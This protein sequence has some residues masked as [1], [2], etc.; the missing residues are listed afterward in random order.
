M[1]PIWLLLVGALS[2]YSAQDDTVKVAAVAP[3]IIDGRLDDLCW[4]RGAWQSIDQVWITYGQKLDPGDFSGRYK[5][6]WSPSSGLLYLLVETVDDV[7]VDGYV[8]NRNPALGGGYPDYD[9]LEVFIDHNRSGGFHVF[10]GKGST[11]TQW[12]SNA[13]N[14]FSYHIA[15]QSRGDGQPVSDK[16]V[17]DIAGESWSNYTIADYAFHFPDFV[18]IRNGRTTIWEF[19]LRVYTDQYLPSQPATSV[20]DLQPGDLIGLS[21]AYCDND[22]PNESPKK[23]DHFIGSVRVPP[24]AYNDHWMNAD[25]FGVL[26]LLDAGA[27]VEEISK[28]GRT[29]YNVYPNP[30]RGHFNLATTDRFER[31]TVYNLL[32]QKVHEQSARIFQTNAINLSDLPNGV[33]LLQIDKG[34]GT[35]WQ[36]VSVIRP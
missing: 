36:K 11:A 10:D 12:G 35:A 32:G 24:A 25:G 1:K 30:S 2:V 21:L 29:G 27:G 6:V 20:A 34:D 7:W 28:P 5:I 16:V 26:R 9:I 17:C 15:V 4:Q 18:M 3:P 22:D 23:R 8:Y 19:S 31:I 33:Y 13:A 14:A